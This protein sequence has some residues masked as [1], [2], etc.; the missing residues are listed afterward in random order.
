MLQPGAGHRNLQQSATR[1][2]SWPVC[3]LSQIHLAACC[4]AP[5]RV[6]MQDPPAP[7]ARPKASYAEAPISGDDSGQ[8][9]DS[10]QD[11]PDVVMAEDPSEGTSGG[12][13]DAEG[14]HRDEVEEEA[15]PQEAQKR[16]SR[17]KKERKSSPRKG[18][19]VSSRA[20]VSVKDSLAGQSMPRQDGISMEIM[21][22]M[23][24]APKGWPQ[25][26]PLSAFSRAVCPD[27]ASCSALAGSK[28]VAKA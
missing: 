6:A 18:E 12:S 23:S 1:A 16:S 10:E 2:T 15:S 11:D 17:R 13:G 20:K 26:P 22:G 7:R 4:P 14:S 19:R 3:S 21:N 9:G 8:D 25:K 27:V 28:V 24:D 5:I